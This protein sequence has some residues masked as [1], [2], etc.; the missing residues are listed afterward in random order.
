MKLDGCYASPES[1]DEGY[2]EY[3]KYLNLTNR[4]IVYSCSWPA[5]LNENEANYK[6]IAEHCNLWRNW[7]DIDDSYS[8]VKTISN[9]FAKQ[10]DYFS[11]YAGVGAWNDPD[12]L[13]V[14]NFGLSPDQAR[15]Q[16]AIWAILAAPLLISADMDSIMEH[17][18]E[19]L[20]NHHAIAI[21]QDRQGTPGRRIFSSKND[22]QQV[23]TR[24]LDGD[25]VAVALVSH[26]VDGMPKLISFNPR[27]I[28]IN[29]HKVYSI[30]NV[31]DEHNGQSEY[32]PESNSTLRYNVNV[33]G[34]VFLRFDPKK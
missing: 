31:F 1:M 32:I 17:N 6:K 22:E 18:R 7:G 4:P 10:Q 29:K 15:T 25:S 16:M 14:G 5:Y 24:F 2:P 21:N 23:W 9:Y 30:L 20:L 19:I 3:G 34:C 11:K 12:M 8:A 33:S 28:G 13:L 27:T 26:H